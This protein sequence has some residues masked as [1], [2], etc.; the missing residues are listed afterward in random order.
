[1]DENEGIVNEEIGSENIDEVAVFSSK[2]KNYKYNPNKSPIQTGKN[3]VENA[4]LTAGKTAKNTGRVINATGKGMQVAGTAAQVAG[5]GMQAVGKGASAAGDGLMQAGSALSSTGLGAIAGVPLTALGGVA[6]GAGTASQAAGKGVD[7]AGKATKDAGKKVS[8]VGKNVTKKGKQIESSGKKLKTPFNKNNQKDIKDKVKKATQNGMRNIKEGAS[9][10]K[11]STNLLKSPGKKIGQ[12]IL[13]VAKTIKAIGQGDIGEALRS[14]A[15]LF[16]KIFGPMLIVIVFVVL[17]IYTIFSPLIE[18]LKKIDEGIT[19]TANVIEKINNLYSGFGFQNTKDAFFDQAQILQ[20]KYNYE[21]DMEL[22]MSTIFYTDMYNGYET[23]L[24]SSSDDTN[25]DPTLINGSSALLDGGSSKDFFSKV[26]ES[27]REYVLDKVEEAESTTDENGLT[28]TV[29]KI[30]RLRKLARNQ[31]ETGAFGIPKRQGNYVKKSLS[32]F[33]DEYGIM[34]GD[35][36]LNV[37]KSFVG[38]SW[39]T[40]ITPFKALLHLLLFDV[41]GA[42]DSLSEAV[43]AWSNVEESMTDLLGVLFFGIVADV[44]V[45]YDNGFKVSYRTYQRSDESY[46]AY[47]KNYY[48]P[49]MPEFSQYVYN[50]DGTLNEDTVDRIISEIYESRDMY[51]DIFGESTKVIVENYDEACSGAVN[52]DVVSMLTLPVDIDPTNCINFSSGYGYGLTSSGIDHKG[53]DF[54]SYTTHNKQGD[55]VYSIASGGKILESSAD[56]TYN[57][58]DCKGGCLKVEYNVNNGNSSYNFKVV[59]EGM[60]KTSVTLKK[61]DSLEKGTILGTIGSPEESEYGS[62]SSLHFAYIDSS[63]NTYIDP[64]NIVIQCSDHYEGDT[65]ADKVVN[66]LRSA[67]TIHEN[68]KKDIQLAAIL[69]NLEQESGVSFESLQKASDDFENPPRYSGSAGSDGHAIGIAQWDGRRNGLMDYAA[70]KGVKWYNHDIQLNYLIGELTE[71]G[72][73]DGYA[74]FQLYNASLYNQFINATNIDDATI[75]Y[76]HGFE[77]CGKCLD[78]QRIAYANNWYAKIVSGEIGGTS[79][80]YSNDLR[81]CSS[82]N[83]TISGTNSDTGE[84]SSNSK[85]EEY[86]TW[87]INTA[88]DE[89]VGYSQSSRNLNPNVDC[90]SFVYFGLTKTGIIQNQGSPFTTASMGN[91]L[92]SNGFTELPFDENILK[93]GDIFV[94]PG[95]H[96]GVYIGDN[97]SVEAH[98]D[99]D[100]ANGDST[101]KE[102]NVSNFTNYNYRYIYRLQ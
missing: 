4:K 79:V 3:I 22:L 77:R 34:I 87:L 44:K 69:G 53:I 82:N 25:G 40:F 80:T 58:T 47:L 26:V 14:V 52:R 67:T 35:A 39:T 93:R 38:A 2:R 11:D 5:K 91:I 62:I 6:K 55:N 12:S 18:T 24:F 8:D 84:I 95:E 41:D 96:T 60:S 102:V 64:T 94:S 49:F 71:G 86:I 27:L 51:V 88:N 97:K 13:K 30:Y 1:M 72:G 99:Y 50:N 100:G 101:G 66:A 9:D 65:A 10:L 15:S 36:L 85:I 76:S 28:Y 74:T 16:L 78:N 21:L 73:A 56:N 63:S 54:N 37:L 70:S 81:S 92:K 45:T 90:S 29:G 68:I 59:Y 75:A 57:G 23:S 31:F 42:I 89:S 61:D 20:R 17:M 98:I 7:A 46:R 33:L 32:S 19:Q 48:I 43:E 83:L